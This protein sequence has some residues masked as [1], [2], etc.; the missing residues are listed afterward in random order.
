MVSGCSFLG[1]W[2]TISFFI[3]VA[4]TFQPAV[5]FTLP[6]HKLQHTAVVP[7][8]DQQLL[9]ALAPAGATDQATHSIAFQYQNMFLYKHNLSLGQ[10]ERGLVNIG[11]TNLRLRQVVAALQAGKEVSIG[12]L[13]GSVSW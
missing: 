2:M 3:M 8:L 7:P 5:A 4:T 6:F 12:I 10:Q 11:A 13:G 1:I 9:A